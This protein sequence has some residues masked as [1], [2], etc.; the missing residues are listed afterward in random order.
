MNNLKE[1]N[2]KDELNKLLNNLTILSNKINIKFTIN[3]I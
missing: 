2:Q 1:N 3:S